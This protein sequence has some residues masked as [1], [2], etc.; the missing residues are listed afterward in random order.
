MNTFRLA[1]LIAWK[2][3]RTEFRSRH[4]FL[5]T[6]FFAFLVLVIFN[7]VFEPGSPALNAARPG[8]LWVAILFAG[9][10]ALGQSFQREREEECLLGLLLAPIPRGAVY[11]GKLL[12]NLVFLTGMELLLLPA[13][14]VL[15][16]AV[17]TRPLLLAATLLL[18]NLGFAAVGT[19]FAAMTQ[20]LRGR[21]VLLPILLLPII[22]PLAIAGVRATALALAP[23]IPGDATPWLNLLAAFDLLFTVVCY[24]AFRHV[25]EETG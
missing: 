3:L 21:D 22:V 24:H 9:M 4:H 11:L 8:I 1:G 2:D 17:P 23:G 15:F 7:F 6:A 18:A 5:T 12:A 20:G 14:V 13:F 10:I 19:L 25:M 16:N